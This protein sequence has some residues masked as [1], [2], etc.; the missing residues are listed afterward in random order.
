MA[1]NRSVKV[2]LKLTALRRTNS[3]FSSPLEIAANIV[4]GEAFEAS[5]QNN[6]SSGFPAEISV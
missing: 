2:M 6:V 5:L 1:G 4:M 3:T